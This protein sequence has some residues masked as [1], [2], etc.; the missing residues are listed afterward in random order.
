MKKEG[1]LHPCTIQFIQKYNL[2]NS[3]PNML[4]IL[5]IILAIAV[6]V[7]TYERSLLKPKL[8]KNY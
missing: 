1:L 6:S 4:I 2:G 7:P 8:I 3:V 5:Q